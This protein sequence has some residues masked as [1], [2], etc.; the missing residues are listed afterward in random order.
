MKAT[1][2]YLKQLGIVKPTLILDK[3]QA[4]RNI[5]HMAQKAIQN[6]VTLRPHFKTHQS[7]SVGEFF[8][9][10]GVWM[11][12]TSSLDMALYFAECG[13]TDITVA[14]PVNVLQMDLINKL[15]DM[16]QLSLLVDSIETVEAL[17]LGLTCPVQVWLEVDPGYKRTG[18][19]WNDLPQALA[20]VEAVRQTPKCEFVGLLSHAGHSYKAT[21]KAEIRQVYEQSLE[22]LKHV[23]NHLHANGIAPCAISFGDTPTASVVDDW[24][25][26]D[27]LRPGNFLFYDLAQEQIGSCSSEQIAVAVACPVIGKYPD[28]QEVVV[29]GGAVHLSKEGLEVGPG[30]VIYGYPTT[31]QNNTFGS[32]LTQAPVVSTSQ[33]HGSLHIT[34]PD[35]F[36][37]ITL[38][39]LLLILPVHSCLTVNLFSHYK[40]LQG[41][42]YDI[43]LP[44]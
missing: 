8:R 25:G 21:T 40:D 30:R 38:G 26:V 31:I 6:G 14:I 19:Q 35:L 36:D 18:V 34:D 33:E 42:T 32:A 20:V 7:A 22:R 17:K 1:S 11:I 4:L 27:E 24:L 29:H 16:I 10:N 37:K 15:A 28:R 13:W 23:Q 39:D 2:D 3:G 44:N 43:M 41:I 5:R 12:T 9:Q